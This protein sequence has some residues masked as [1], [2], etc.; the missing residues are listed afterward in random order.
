MRF[1]KYVRLFCKTLD[2]IKFKIKIKEIS[3]IDIN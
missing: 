1:N 3:D 2:K